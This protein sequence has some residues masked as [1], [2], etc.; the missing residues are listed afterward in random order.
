LTLV[1]HFMVHAYTVVPR[2]AWP[3]SCWPDYTVDYP[4]VD[5]YLKPGPDSLARH[6]DLAP[7]AKE[8]ARA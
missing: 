1:P 8:Q 7:E 3:G 2:G 5:E 4:A 6:L